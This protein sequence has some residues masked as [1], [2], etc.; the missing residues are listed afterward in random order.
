M[1]IQLDSVEAKQ[2][3]TLL[4]FPDKGTIVAFPAGDG[5]AFAAMT[6]GQN[7]FKAGIDQDGTYLGEVEK[8]FDVFVRGD[9]LD[10]Y[11]PPASI[12][13]V[14]LQLPEEDKLPHYVDW[15]SFVN[16]LL[17][18]ANGWL[19]K[20]G[21]VIMALSRGDMLVANSLIASNFRDLTILSVDSDPEKAERFVVLGRAYSMFEKTR[22]ADPEG[23]R[24]R[25]IGNLLFRLGRGTEDALKSLDTIETARPG[26]FTIPAG[27][28][29]RPHSGSLPL[30]EVLDQL[31]DSPACLQLETLLFRTDSHFQE[32]PLTPLHGGHV[33]VLATSGLINGIFGKGDERHVA[34][35]QCCKVVDS[36][37]EIEGEEEVT[38]DRES[39]VTRVNIAYQDGTV[40][41][42][43]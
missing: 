15:Y 5:K 17:N 27:R 31:A 3:G 32:Q 6:K 23:D 12:A 33:G 42:L 20:D 18:K 30:D 8:N 43:A 1:S 4:S 34:N 2:I 26:Q 28:T 41:T 11:A 14:F 24:R 16:S 10:A 19:K 22:V 9:I 7:I 25:H 37:E 38:R 35:W 36:T 39:F 40:M 13:A 29:I 21:V